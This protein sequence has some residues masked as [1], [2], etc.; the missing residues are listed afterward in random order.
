MIKLCSNILGPESGLIRKFKV[1]N[2]RLLF[3]VLR[4]L[5]LESKEKLF[6]LARKTKIKKKIENNETKGNEENPREQ[7]CDGKTLFPVGLFLVV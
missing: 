7:Q 5:P 3:Y 4:Y 6:S 2:F 1:V